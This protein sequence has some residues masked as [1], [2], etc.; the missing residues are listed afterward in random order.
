MRQRGGPRLFYIAQCS[1]EELNAIYIYFY[2][3]VYSDHEFELVKVKSAALNVVALH[4]LLSVAP[5]ARL[6]PSRLSL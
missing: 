5:L 4:G 6:K 2:I 3:R 1:L